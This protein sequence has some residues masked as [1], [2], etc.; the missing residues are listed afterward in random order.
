MKFNLLAIFSIIVFGLVTANAQTLEYEIEISLD[1]TE[2]SKSAKEIPVGVKITNKSD[3]VLVTSG[4]KTI[5]FFFS[6]CVLGVVCKEKKH[7]YSAF[8]E[9]PFKRIKSSAFFEFEI[10]LADLYWKDVDGN[11]FYREDKKNFKTVPKENIYFYARQL[12]LAGHERFGNKTIPIYDYKDS[13]VLNVVL[14]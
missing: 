6:K 13:N 9:I 7:T 11:T 5:H 10:N 12:T 2:I 8:T 1:E 4:L 14:N 3:E